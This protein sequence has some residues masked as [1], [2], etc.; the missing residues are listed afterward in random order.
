M[1]GPRSNPATAV[2]F[3]LAWA[4]V[5]SCGIAHEQ[6]LGEARCPDYDEQISPCLLS[7]R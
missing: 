5:S 1:A 6:N 4:G 7:V 2:L 3:A